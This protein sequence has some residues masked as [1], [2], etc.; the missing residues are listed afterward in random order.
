MPRFRIKP[1]SQIG[2]PWEVLQKAINVTLGYVRSDL[3]MSSIHKACN[4]LVNKGQNEQ[5]FKMLSDQLKTHFETWHQQLSIDAGDPLI[6]KLYDQYKDFKNYC[7]VF[8]K[9]YMSYDRYYKN[10]EPNKVL[11]QIRRLFIKIILSD[12]NLFENAVTPSILKI[13]YNAQKGLDIDL[14]KISSLIDMYY[15]FRNSFEK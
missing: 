12:S 14:T 8:P 13:I 3:R 2:D 1:N 10:E 15:S 4:E 5:I 9:F 11:N 7:S 6:T